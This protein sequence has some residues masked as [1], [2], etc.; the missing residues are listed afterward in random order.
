M[1]MVP[2]TTHT[3]YSGGKW[4]PPPPTFS[5]HALS[6]FGLPV[7]LS[8]CPPSAWA[9]APAAALAPS[10][11]QPRPPSP[12]CA[13]PSSLSAAPFPPLAPSVAARGAGPGAR[14]RRDRRS[15]RRGEQASA[16]P[17]RRA[18]VVAPPA[19]AYSAPPVFLSPRRRS[20]L[21]PRSPS[22][23]PRPSLSL[24][25]RGA[26]ASPAPFAGRRRELALSTAEDGARGRS[27]LSSTAG[28]AAAMARGPPPRRRRPRTPASLLRPSSPAALPVPAFLVLAGRNSGGACAGGGRR[29]RGA[30]PPSW[31]GRRPPALRPRAAAAA[32][33]RGGGT[34]QRRPS[35]SGKQGRRPW[36]FLRAAAR[37]PSASPHLAG[38]R[39][40][41][42]QG[43][44]GRGVAASRAG[45]RWCGG[46]RGF[47]AIRDGQWWYERACEGRWRRRA[48][49]GERGR[50][51]GEHGRRRCRRASE[52]RAMLAR[53]ERTG[54][55]L[56]SLDGCAIIACWIESTAAEVFSVNWYCIVRYRV[57]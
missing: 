36:S 13:G 22:L 4:D 5:P 52:S 15:R 24:A 41:G 19:L 25:L 37:P 55:A 23:P 17:G 20:S 54:R 33:R 43:R 12:P 7:P 30:I 18:H 3:F 10:A 32:A 2:D 57:G 56:N 8:P 6:L 47:G 49:A 31:H 9:H 21:P 29:S 51:A 44:R 34:E 46:A 48:Q 1:I 38:P 39:R 35:C 14:G 40:R 27:G 26:G 11:A 16:A 50:R 42:E 45:R 53:T 28:A